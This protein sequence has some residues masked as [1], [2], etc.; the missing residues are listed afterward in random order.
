VN[1]IQN[2]YSG[3]SANKNL[4]ARCVTASNV[5]RSFCDCTRP[6]CADCDGIEPDVTLSWAGVVD[7]RDAHVCAGCE[8]RRQDAAAETLR[9][10]EAAE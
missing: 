8:E 7:G 9:L 6:I 10:Q 4:C 1:T 3:V 5:A 2:H